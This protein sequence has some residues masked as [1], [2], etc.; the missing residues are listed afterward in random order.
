MVSHILH[1]S[2]FWPV[3]VIGQGSNSSD[4]TPCDGMWLH[5]LP[6]LIKLVARLFNAYSGIKMLQRQSG[7][8]IT[9]T[10]T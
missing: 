7:T 5:V 10:L 9:L 2:D 4:F 8:Y 1:A 3:C 6:I